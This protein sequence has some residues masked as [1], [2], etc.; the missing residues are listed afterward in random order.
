MNEHE[1]FNVLL[2]K[3][4]SIV[5]EIE[6]Q[7]QTNNMDTYTDIIIQV[8][9]EKGEISTYLNACPNQKKELEEA[10]KKA[11]ELTKNADRNI[12]CKNV[13]E[14]FESFYGTEFKSIRFNDKVVGD[15][16]GIIAEIGVG[17][18]MKKY[19]IKTHHGGSKRSNRNPQ[20]SVAS[21][22]VRLNYK[23]PFIYKF[24]ETIGW[25]CESHFI[26]ENGSNYEDYFYIA[27]LDCE[28]KIEADSVRS[29][30]TYEEFRKS[31]P[32]R[33]LSLGDK[34]VGFLSTIDIISRLL[35]L[36]DVLL[37]PMNFGFVFF[38]GKVESKAKVIDFI[39]P[40]ERETYRYPKA[41]DGFLA[42]NG[43]YVYS[44]DLIKFILKE[45][46]PGDK[47]RT[48]RQILFEIDFERSF[49]IALD[50][51]GIT[52][53][54]FMRSPDFQAYLIAIRENV[55]DFRRECCQE[56]GAEIIRN[57]TKH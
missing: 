53:E 35:G 28:F 47:V 9:E 39:P 8:S 4:R 40:S 7:G 49:D 27:T 16:F 15:N 48:A 31:C 25:G 51:F 45:R 37:N 26:V 52:K 56:K 33:Q 42:G 12:M 34:I 21:S 41:F 1:R 3:V 38:N 19:Y 43:R 44:D 2:L 57:E 36:D 11:R 18:V 6:T 29:F 32:Q 23:E 10:I 30:L 14:Y 46:A 24:L 55:S 54:D 5:N 13:R 50:K 20:E 22:R 17:N